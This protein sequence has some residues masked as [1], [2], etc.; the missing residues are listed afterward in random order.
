MRYLA[1]M[2]IIHR[3]LQ[4]ENIFVTYN[5]VTRKRKEEEEREKERVDVKLSARV[6][7]CKISFSEE[8]A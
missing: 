2:N 3:N 7:W 4:P 8:V 6:S 5:Q 1:S